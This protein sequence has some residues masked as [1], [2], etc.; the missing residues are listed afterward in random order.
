[1]GTC[2]NALRVGSYVVVMGQGYAS[3]PLLD[4]RIHDI[5]VVADPNRHAPAAPDPVGADGTPEGYSPSSAAV[6]FVEMLIAMATANTYSW[7]TGWWPVL[8]SRTTGTLASGGTYAYQMAVDL[9]SITVLE[10]FV[11]DTPADD[12]LTDDQITLMAQTSVLDLFA[13]AFTVDAAILWGASIVMG[14][15]DILLALVTKVPSPPQLALLAGLVIV[16]TA[17]MFLGLKMLWDGVLS[18][19]VSASAAFAILVVTLSALGIEGALAGISGWKIFARWWDHYKQAG[20]QL[21]AK[22]YCF[23]SWVIFCVKM[24]FI[25]IVLAM[26]VRVCNFWIQG[27]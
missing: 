17:A 3:N 26:L 4:M 18:G 5:T 16:Y 11:V 9:L 7:W 20:K 24:M 1:M 8:H 15:I 2:D 21:W 6:S 23:M 22:R 10:D 13:E 19:R 27:Y 25:A 12:H 14:A